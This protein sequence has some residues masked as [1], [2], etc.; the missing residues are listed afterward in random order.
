MKKSLIFLI[1]LSSLLVAA[2]DNTQPAQAK[3]R[4]FKLTLSETQI[5][6][7]VNVLNSTSIKGSEAEFIVDLKRTLLSPQ[8]EVSSNIK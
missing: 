6:G 5:L 1:F 3:L 7:L 4:Y 2:P 8:E